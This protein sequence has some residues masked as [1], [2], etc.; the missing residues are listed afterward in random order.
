MTRKPGEGGDS[1]YF[2]VGMCHCDSD[3]L[4]LYSTMFTMYHGEFYANNAHNDK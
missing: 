2:L 3:T 1:G 4:T